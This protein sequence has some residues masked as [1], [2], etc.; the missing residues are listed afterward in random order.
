MEAMDVDSL[1][2]RNRFMKLGVWRTRTSLLLE[3]FCCDP[4]QRY[5]FVRIRSFEL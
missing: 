2:R 1:E 3:R 4:A 5:L